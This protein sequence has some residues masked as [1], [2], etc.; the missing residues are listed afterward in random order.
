MTDRSRAMTAAGMTSV[1]LG[2]IYTAQITGATT[3]TV[4]VPNAANER[5]WQHARDPRKS[6]IDLRLQIGRHGK[7]MLDDKA[8]REI[9]DEPADNAHAQIHP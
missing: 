6:R 7:H 5:E 4:D 8:P 3:P 1:R 2:D 9:K